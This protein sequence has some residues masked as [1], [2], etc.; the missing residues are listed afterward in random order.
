[1]RNRNLHLTSAAIVVVIAA[2]YWA[3]LFRR[4]NVEA[5]HDLSH[6][7]TE[8]SLLS[9]ARSS[10]AKTALNSS[11]SDRPEA[12]GAPASGQL[13]F[14]LAGQS[15][16]PA[17]DR[18]VRV[19]FPLP[20]GRRVAGQ[21]NLVQRDGPG[22]VHVGGELVGVSDGSFAFN[23]KGETIWGRIL[24]PAEGLAYEFGPAAGGALVLRAKQLAEVMCFPLPRAVNEPAAAVPSGPVGAPPVLSSHPTATAVLYLDFDGETVTD[25]AWNRGNTIV[26]AP[27][28][29]SAAQITEAWSK[30]KEDFI[31]FNIDVTTDVTRYNNAPVNRR[32]RCIITPTSAWY[33]SYVGGVAFIGAFRDA[34]GN[35]S[36]TVPCWVF[37]S[38]PSSIAEAV[39]H[40]FGHTLGLFHHGT[41]TGLTYYPGHG[42]GAVSWAPLMGSSYSAALSQWS[43]GEYLGADNTS[44]DDIAIIADTATN[45]F[46][47]IADDAGNSRA[48]AALLTAPGGTI[49]QSGIIHSSA[50]VDFFRVTLTGPSAFSITA[51][52]AAV[53]PNLDL[54]LELQDA[55][56]VVLASSNPDLQITA[57][58]SEALGAG[59]YYVKV[60]GVGRGLVLGDGY[61]NYGSIGSYSLTGTLG[62]VAPPTITGQPVAQ[63]VTAGSAL[64][65]SV[66]ATS[67][68]PLR[69]E[70][71]QDGA[72]LSGAT[73]S[74]LTL[75]NVGAA[76]AGSYG[77]VVTNAAGSVT[78][79]S[80]LLT[81]LFPPL[82]GTQP[83]NASVE[84]GQRATFTVSATG[85]APLG[86]AW[87]KN[88]SAIA[89]AI[90]A[91]FVVPAA[92]VADAGNYTVV[93]TNAAGST[94]SD[95]A[96]LTVT[97]PP[98]VIGTHPVSQVVNL[99]AQVS[100]GVS[101]SG[102]ALAYQWRKNGVMIGNGTG[103][104]YAVPSA[105]ASDAGSYDVIVSNAGGS[106]T[107]NAATLIV[108]LPPAIT[109]A[110][111]AQAVAVGGD[112]TLSVA[113]SGLAPLAFQWSKNGI[114]ISG[115]T[116]AALTLS[117]AQLPDAANYAVTVSNAV[118]AVVS[119]NAAVNVFPALPYATHAI[120][121]NGYRPGGTLTVT[122][123]LGY[124][125]AISGLGWE[126]LIPSGWTF[127]S[128]GGNLGN[129][130]PAVGTTGL[131]EWAWTTPPASPMNFSYTLAVPAGQTGEVQLVTRV[132]VRATGASATELLAR[133]D[134]LVVRRETYHAADTDYDFALSLFELTR[135]IELYNT[136]NG[137]VRT[138]AY[139]VDAGGEDG[140][141]A[142][143]ARASNVT[144]ALVLYHSA[145]TRGATPGP[146]P[147]GKI[148]LFELTRII[149]LYNTR[150]G[151]V[152]TGRYHVQ[153]G[154]EDGFAAGP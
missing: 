142:D 15:Q 144:T 25:P 36:D 83:Q 100:F 77:V 2:G 153:G 93:V 150:S 94:M 4:A 66:A 112:I 133:P 92:Q 54:G 108:R 72:V 35:F 42:S 46:G 1:M 140:F 82:I 117:N 99:G 111:R 107:S 146:G 98:P 130:A 55:N 26:A 10:G 127:V 52:P 148:D 76:S 30:V 49:A 33:P 22:I 58:I 20:D 104:T 47:F 152:R 50:D 61:S 125:G 89:G 21:V 154:T 135:V 79:N 24:L 5:R 53:G 8:E 37:N 132:I 63:T 40:E 113:A 126:V 59:T 71:R 9:S 31:P 103:S 17:I 28:N 84:F 41:T 95:I 129:V 14:A 151:T 69:Y 3:T 81:V 96:A 38:S 101:A 48:T 116:A 147:D 68:V 45:G 23:A 128:A 119:A 121:V 138:G 114:A 43:K 86:Y 18:G 102:A 67:T 88:G 118:G 7:V 39:S 120:A 141:T 78:S 123:A 136:R 122:N 80:A 57:D 27:A 115:A 74:T 145:D 149:E 60:Q 87:R 90:A 97:L 65:F 143:P 16:L 62:T 110:P 105:L 6:P 109:T 131:V 34:N 13:L 12:Q 70:W 51:N 64:T 44:Q 106:V 73:K 139:R 124:A 134:P 85:T 19:N 11:T 32:S 29:L 91:T 137:T 75:T 56:G